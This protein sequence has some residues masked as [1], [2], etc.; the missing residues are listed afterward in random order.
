VVT[1]AGLV[2]VAAAAAAWW[3]ARGLLTHF[4]DGGGAVY[5]P[6]WPTVGATGTLLGGAMVALL[7]AG[8]AAALLL[9]RRAEGNR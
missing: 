2:A 4:V 3:L 9:S 1:A 6:A 7:V 8:T 5:V